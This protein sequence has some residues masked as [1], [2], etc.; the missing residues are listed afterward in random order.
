LASYLAALAAAAAVPLIRWRSSLGQSK[1][2]ATTPLPSMLTGEMARISRA[3]RRL[4][5]LAPAALLAYV[6]ILVFRASS[7]R[8]AF[9]YYLLGAL[10][11][12]GSTI[13][14][15]LLFSCEQP[16]ATSNVLS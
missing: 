10:Q 6:P 3:A 12:R 16:L 11:A 2:L 8:A 9:I 7:F 4:Y 15:Q 1:L 13:R 5:C 14:L